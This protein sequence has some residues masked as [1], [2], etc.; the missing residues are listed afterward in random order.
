MTLFNRRY[1]TFY[2]SAIATRPIVMSCTIFEL[3]I[4]QNIVTLK[5]RL[6]VT[7]SAIAS[8]I[9]SIFYRYCDIQRLILAWPWNL[10]LWSL[11]HW[12]WSRS[13]N[14]YTTLYWSAVITIALSCTY[15]E[16]FWRSKYRDLEILVSGH[17]RSLEIAHSI[18]R[19][20]V[21][22]HCNNGRILY[23]FR[24][25]ARYWSKNAIFHTPLYLL[26]TIPR[27]PFELSS[28]ILIQTVRVPELLG[29]AKVLSKRSSLYL[30][31]NNVTDRR[32]TDDRRTA[33]AIS[34]T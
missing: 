32:Q 17:S 14:D 15:I 9:V 29:G 24:N 26:C 21:P 25:K 10:G 2:Q 3:F 28:K 4:V 27:N 30:Q 8:S 19:I 7:Q 22:I 1:T 33:H 20:R 13:I 18:D 12:T 34:R 31:C 5:S 16:F 6:G 23:H 11:S